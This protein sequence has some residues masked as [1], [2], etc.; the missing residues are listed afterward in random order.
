MRRV[1]DEL[2]RA[3]GPQHKMD[4]DMLIYTIQFH[5]ISFDDKLLPTMDTQRSDPYFH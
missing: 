4:Y 5:S 3:N 1:N 2:T